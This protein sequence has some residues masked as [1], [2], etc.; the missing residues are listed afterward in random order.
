MAKLAISFCQVVRNYNSKFTRNALCICSYN[1]Y[2]QFLVRVMSQNLVLSFSRKH[3][4]C[5]SFSSQLSASQVRTLSTILRDHNNY[6]MF[7]WQPSKCYRLFRPLNKLYSHYKHKIFVIYL[8]IKTTGPKRAQKLWP[9]C[10]VSL[11]VQMIN[12]THDFLDIYNV[13]PSI[14]C[15]IYY[16]P[17]VS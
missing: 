10:R 14:I 7:H 1:I 15:I 16:I 13:I 9:S 12:A 5:F 17:V 8:S 6:N 11:R 2:Q 3:C 4:S